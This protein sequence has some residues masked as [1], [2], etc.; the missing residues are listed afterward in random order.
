MSNAPTS[1]AID[2][3]GDDTPTSSPTPRLSWWPVSGSGEGAQPVDR[4]EVAAVIDGVAAA[5]VV[6]SGHSFVPWPWESLRSE[7]SV[8]WQ[9]RGVLGA[10]TTTDWSKPHAF[11]AGLFEQDWQAQWIG[12]VRGVQEEESGHRPT[13]RLAT[14]FQ[15]MGKVRSARLY[16]TALGLYEAF[17]N[18]S[19]AGTVELTPGST[20]YD[21]TLYAQSCDVTGAVNSGANRLEIL[22]SDGWY[23]GQVGAFRAPAAWGT[24]TAARVELHLTLEDGS[25]QVVA[26]DGTWVSSPSQIRAASLMEGQVTDLTASL[27]EPVPVVVL[28]ADELDAPGVSW[29]PAPPVRVVDTLPV[30]EL[31][32]VSQNVWVADFGQNASGWIALADLGPRGIRT[33]IDYGEHVGPDGDLDTSHLDSSRPGEP[34]KLFTQQD[35]VISDGMGTRF[36]PRH[37]VHG[38]RYARISRDMA[39]VSGAPTHSE[40]A[41]SWGDAGAEGIVGKQVGEQPTQ[42]DPASITMRVVHTD[43]RRT[44]TFECSDQELVRLHEAAEWSFRG[45]AVDVPTDCPTRERLGWTGDYQ[46]FAPTATRLFD[47]LGFTKKWLQSVRDDQFPDGRIANFSPDGRRI[48]KNLN[49]QFAM[50]SGSAGWGDAIVLVPWEMYRTYGDAQVLADNWQAMVC[51]VGWATEVARTRRHPSRIERSAEPLPHEQYIWDGSFHWGEW[52]EPK[53]KRADGTLIDPVQD[54]PMAWFGA[55]KGEVGTAFLY[56]STRLL[57]EI[58]GVLGRAEEADQYAY[59]AEKI[60]EAWQTEFLD[61]AGRTQTHSQASY[62]RALSFGLIPDHLRAA[63]AEHLAELVREVDGHL[64]TGFLS[65]GD[66]LPVLTDNGYADLAGEVLRQRTSPSWLY[67]LDQGATTIWEDWDGV[68]EHGRAHESLNHY[69]KG[70]VIRF[71]HTHILGLRQAE[72]SVGWQLVELDPVA[73]GGVDWARGTHVSPQGEIRVE[74]HREGAGLRLEFSIPAATQARVRGIDGLFG[75]GEHAVL[76]PSASDVVAN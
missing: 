69:S 76:L 72:D 64:G 48:K 66:L 41:G 73:L 55:D 1:L 51:W 33:T 70:A 12:P 59:E 54:N 44:G 60:R 32:Q 37:T 28:S 34:T 47:V 49:D 39:P 8:M 6:V 50:M 56:R 52:I 67:M 17:V 75:P 18:G 35:Q 5:P 53:Q 3:L 63:A 31:A 13:Y 58:A 4:Y 62:V 61:D 25:R 43:F 19:R 71:F 74:W 16:A 46:V 7:Q 20:S 15:V 11:M 9:V 21:S 2:F 22:L 30:R 68:D 45:N 26:S 23:A 57:G 10:G 29:S 36:E 40:P 14:E 27:S 24:T 38:F 42:L 65:T